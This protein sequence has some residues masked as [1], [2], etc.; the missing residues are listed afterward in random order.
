[1]ISKPLRQIQHGTRGAGLAERRGCTEPHLFAVVVEEAVQDRFGT[2]ITDQPQGADD[3]RTI[4]SGSFEILDHRRDRPG[5]KPG[6]RIANP[7]SRPIVFSIELMEN[8]SSRPVI[9]YSGQGCC[10]VDPDLGDRVRQRHHQFLYRRGISHLRQRLRGANPHLLA[11]VAQIA[12]KPPDQA[13]LLRNTQ[14]VVAL[15]PLEKP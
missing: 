13:Q 3:Q 1:M 5:A 4:P 7:M 8:R 11:S 9:S 10:G 2:R 15:S 14:Q 6:Q 12:R